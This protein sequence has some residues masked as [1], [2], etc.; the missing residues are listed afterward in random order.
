MDTHHHNSGADGAAA[1]LV[2]TMVSL[3][4]AVV[5]LV[6][7]FAWAPWDD[8]STVNPGTGTEEGAG[9]GDTDVN[10]DGDI[11]VNG[12]GGGGDAESSPTP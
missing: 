6:A 12:G 8:D 11:D 2:A 5:L 1:W 9:E 3:F 10:I 4:V 7:F